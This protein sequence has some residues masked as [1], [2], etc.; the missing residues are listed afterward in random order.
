M[1]NDHP[2][3]AIT[4]YT[5]ALLKDNV[6]IGGKVFPQKPNKAM[7]SQL[8]CVCIYF[9]AE[10]VVV[11]SGDSYVPTQYERQLQLAIDVL[12]QQQ[13]TSS[14][15]R[16]EVRLDQWGR[17]IEEAI[18]DDPFYSKRL[19]SCTGNIK[20]DPGLICGARLTGTTPYDISEEPG[21]VTAA[22]QSLVYELPY[23]DYAYPE[24]KWELMTSF[25]MEIR[26]VGWDEA[27]VDPVLI[28]SEEDL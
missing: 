17:Q 11:S 27:T 20:T 18:S 12:V 22:A 25:M 26:R 14:G 23:L 13:V 24:H 2:R 9:I 10:P 15:E 7:L 1:A 5:W 8:P 21:E 4:A 28:A 19:S 3:T 6:D 16:I